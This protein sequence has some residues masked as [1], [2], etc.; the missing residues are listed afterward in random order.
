MYG[1]VLTFMS[2][3]DHFGTKFLVNSIGGANQMRGYRY[4]FLNKPGVVDAALELHSENDES[5][6]ELASEL[7]SRSRCMFVEVR[8]G[9]TLIYSI[10][11]D[12]SNAGSFDAAP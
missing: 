6:C 9:S 2:T 10:R 3:I 11:R 4:R 8:R 7:L 1:S 12:G 5:A